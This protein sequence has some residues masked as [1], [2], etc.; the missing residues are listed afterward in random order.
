MAF[1]NNIKKLT[2]VISEIEYGFADGKTKAI[3]VMIIIR[4]IDK[5]LIII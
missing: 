5:D 4:D 3:L 1:S 2:K